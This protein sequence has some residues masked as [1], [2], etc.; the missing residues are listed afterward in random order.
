MKSY[1]FIIESARV[2][3]MMVCTRSSTLDRLKSVMAQVK[4]ADVGDEK[5]FGEDL[6]AGEV[7]EASH[8]NGNDDAPVS[9]VD[10]EHEQEEATVSTAKAVD[11][12]HVGGG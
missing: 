12:R 10:N 11:F 8:R 5:I 2:A 1:L 4:S 6:K 9:E 7:E 3:T